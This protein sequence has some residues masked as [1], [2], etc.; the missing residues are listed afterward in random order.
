MVQV[1]VNV[2]D[3]FF[4]Q[5]QSAATDAE[6]LACTISHS[7]WEK[8]FCQWLETMHRELP[9]GDAYELS[10][11]FTDN[12]EIQAL[13]AQY[14]YQDQPT[15]VLAFAVLDEVSPTQLPAQIQ[16]SMPLYLGDIVISVETAH[17]QA[18]RQG[19]SLTI[20]LAWLA[21]HG[22][23]HLLGWDHPDQESLIRMLN[24][25]ET[26]LELISLKLRN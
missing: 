6:P 24:Q 1:E 3:L 16:L 20:E 10:L 13:N 25:Q 7:T 18:Q 4:T 19:H 21:S 22:L 5:S 15:D 23:L 11:R 17:Q 14:R 8:W 9:L 26:L 2:Q 12:S